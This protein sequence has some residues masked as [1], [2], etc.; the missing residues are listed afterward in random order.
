MGKFDIAFEHLMDNEGGYSNDPVDSGGKTI[1]GIASKYHKAWFDTVYTA[2]KSRNIEAAKD[3]AKKFY[4][5]KFWDDGYD[6]IRESSLAFRLFDFGVNAGVKRSVKIF[7]K[8]VNY[9]TRHKV[10]K[11]SKLKTKKRFRIWKLSLLLMVPL[12]VLFLMS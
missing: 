2:Y 1:Y 8:C 11:I 4:K 10:L 7:Q 9:L 3:L 5:S 6:K 12:N